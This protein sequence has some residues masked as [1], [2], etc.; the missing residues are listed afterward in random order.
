MRLYVGNLIYTMTEIDLHTLFSH[1]GS[2]REVNLIT[3]HYTRQSKCFGYVHMADRKEGRN[4][5]A[6]LNG[7]K[8]NNLQLVV[9]EAKPRDE[10]YDNPEQR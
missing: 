3:D 1:H 2:V 5:I 9:K 10:R 8:I 6:A 4:A 7:T